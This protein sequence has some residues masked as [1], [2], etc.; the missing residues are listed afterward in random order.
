MMILVNPEAWSPVGVDSLEP[1]ADQVIRSEQNSLVVAGPGA[2]KTELLAQRANYLLETG[3]CASPKRILA[4]SFKRDAADNL[5]ERVARRSP[6]RS[7][8]FDSFTLDAFR[9]G[10]S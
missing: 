8:R 4:I 9:K 5:R 7:E 10:V 2:G 6:N 1:I 3:I